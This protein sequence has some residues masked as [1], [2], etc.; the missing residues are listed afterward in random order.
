LLMLQ[1]ASLSSC[2]CSCSS[3]STP[4]HSMRLPSSQTS[5][6]HAKCSIYCRMLL[7]NTMQHIMEEPP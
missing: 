1:A 4:V 5:A 3:R 6:L 2:S 7:Y